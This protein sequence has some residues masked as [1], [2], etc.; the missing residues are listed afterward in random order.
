MT[1]NLKKLKKAYNHEDKFHNDKNAK[2]AKS[3]LEYNLK[4]KK[5]KEKNNG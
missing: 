3:L 4:I 1:I 5:E 2:F